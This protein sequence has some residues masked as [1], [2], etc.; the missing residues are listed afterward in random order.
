[1]DIVKI[2]QSTSDTFQH[3]YSAV[4]HS[5]SHA[6]NHHFISISKLISSI[7]FLREKGLKM[8]PKQAAKVQL[9]P[10]KVRNKTVQDHQRFLIKANAYNAFQT[11]QQLFLLVKHFSSLLFE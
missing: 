2:E 7:I 11:Q 6:I 4:N 3:G 5:F 10:Y 1:M 9:I 8:C